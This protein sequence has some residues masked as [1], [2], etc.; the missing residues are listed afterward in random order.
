MPTKIVNDKQ[1]IKNSDIKYYHC[2]KLND[3]YYALFDIKMDMPIVIGS[4]SIIKSVK[5]GGK[6]NVVFYYE[7]NSKGFFEKPPYKTIEIS[8][9]GKYQKPPLRYHYI[10][11]NKIIYHHFK[12]N[13]VL[14]TLFDD[15]FEMPIM[16]GSN[17]R[18]Q[19]AINQIGKSSFIFYYK[20]DLLVKNSFKL[21]MV[22][23]NNS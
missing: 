12:L 16:Y 1:T 18:I 20:E 19:S 4:L 21:F 2:Y 17:Q 3:T 15:T 7:L 9:E 22:Y 23:K 10:D 11:K 14:S 6:Q 13:N 5:L 8:G